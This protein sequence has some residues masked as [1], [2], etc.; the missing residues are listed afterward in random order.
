[1]MQNK[2]TI[3]MKGV[4]VKGR[5]KKTNTWAEANAAFKPEESG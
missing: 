4:K 1:M 3:K 5:Q 2:W